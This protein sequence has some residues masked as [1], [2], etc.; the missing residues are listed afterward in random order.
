MAKVQ[1]EKL[2]VVDDMALNRM[3]L[4]EI[5]GNDFEILEAANGLETIELLKIHPDA[6]ALLLDIVMPEMDGFGV[7]EYMNETDLIKTLPVILIT[8][9]ED[10]ATMLKGYAL[11]V[12]DI[13]GKPFNFEI[14]VRRVQNIVALYASKKDMERRL[15]EQ[16][17][18]LEEQAERLKQTNLFVIDALST[19]VEFRNLESGEHI[20]RVRTFTKVLLNSIK[21]SYNLNDT[22]IEAISN[23]SAMHDIG[24]IAIA[25]S[26][27]LKPGPLNRAEFDVMKTHTIRGCEILAT[28]NYTQDQEYYTYCYEICRHHHER[29]DGRGY[30]DGLKGDDISIWAQATSLA[31]VYDALTSKRVYKD[32]Y[33]HEKA[34]EMILNGECGAFNPVLIEGFKCVQDELFRQG[35]SFANIKNPLIGIIG[36]GTEEENSV[37]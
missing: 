15:R 35:N 9:E 28:L 10:Q 3:I 30:P 19:T 14:V 29:W 37:I 23:A 25:D 34:V 33:S 24:K 27:L 26:I 32:A 7:L 20:K 8:G 11:G 22:E 4:A 2:L 12:S 36:L 17:E 18:M 31:D 5:F 13:I 16:K 6:A 21:D 1:K